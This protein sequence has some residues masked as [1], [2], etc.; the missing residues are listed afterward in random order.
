MLKIFERFITNTFLDIGIKERAPSQPRFIGT[1]PLLYGAGVIKQIA[2][3]CQSESLDM[4]SI[5]VLT[6]ENTG[7][8]AGDFITDNFKAKNNV[9]EIKRSFPTLDTA[10]ISEIKKQ[11]LDCRPT[12]L[13]GVGGGSKLDLTKVI[14]TELHLPYVLVPTVLSHDGIASNFASIVRNG[15]KTTIQ[16]KRA[17]LIVADYDILKA[18]DETLTLSGFCDVASN[19]CS[20]NDWKIA[21]QR[22]DTWLFNKKLN[23]YPPKTGFSNK[24]YYVSTLAAQ[25]CLTLALQPKVKNI[26][27]VLEYLLLGIYA[28]DFAMSSAGSSIPCSG[29]EHTVE[30]IAAAKKPGMH[31]LYCGAFSL[32]LLYLQNEDWRFYKKALQKLGAPVAASELGFTKDETVEFYKAALTYRTPQNP[33]VDEFNHK[34]HRYG[35]LNALLDKYSKKSKEPLA[36]VERDVNAAM[37]ATGFI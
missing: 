37:K 3:T 7:K 34:N 25:A 17:E 15:N 11:V 6:G 22:F 28:S 20:A 19:Y 14:A 9:A 36:I 12:L 30:K 2:D 32:P 26:R 13:I 18:A 31:G 1:P 29:T 4:N 8:V 33:L 35:I 27:D 24:I 23:P 21:A 16:T 10:L 5:V